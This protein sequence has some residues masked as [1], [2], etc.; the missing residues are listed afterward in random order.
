MKKMLVFLFSI[1]LASGIS[2]QQYSDWKNYSDLKNVNAFALADNKIWAATSGGVFSYNLSLQDYLILSKTDGLNGESITAVESDSY[3]KIWFGSADGKINV[4]DPSTK[5]IKTVLD[6]FNSDK[7]NKR[8]NELSVKGDTIFAATDFGISLINSENFFFYDTYFKFGTL[9]SNIKVNSIFFDGRIYSCTESGLAISKANAVNLSAPESWDVYQTANG[10]IS[11]NIFKVFSFNDTLIA[12]TDKGFSAFNGISWQP[13]LP[14]YNNQSISDVTIEGNSLVVLSQNIIRSYTNGN[15]TEIFSSPVPLKKLSSHDQFG[16]FAA[17]INGILN[18]TE[19]GHEFFVPNCPAANRFR[20]IIVDQEGVLFCASGKDNG[21]I[22]IM[23]LKNN[24]WSSYN[25]ASNPELQTNDYYSAYSAPDNTKYFGNWGRGFARLKDGVIT[26]F[27]AS[28]TDLVGI[29]EDPEFVVITS[30]KADSKNNIWA[31]NYW[32]AERQSL[33]MLQPN[34]TW[35]HFVVPAEQGRTLQLKFSLVIDAYNTKWYICQDQQKVGL[36]Y[37]NENGTYSETGDDKS[38]FLT[39]ANGLNN[40]SILSLAVDRRGDLWVGTVSGMNILTNTQAALTQSNSQFRISSSFLLRQQSINAIVVDP[41]NQKWV[42][43]NQGLL[44][45]NADGTRLIAA[46]DSRNSSLLSDQIVSLTMDENSG[47]IYA[48]TAEG[49]TSFKTISIKPAESFSE[50]FVYPSP[51]ILNAD[52]T[53]LTIDGLIRDCDIK[54][55]SISG[56]LI[57]K[58]VTPGGRVANW[59]G[60]DDFGNFVSSG[61]YLIVAYDKEGNSVSTTKVAVLRE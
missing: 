40:N 38:G 49:L 12:A 35:H 29:P 43:T 28:N 45:V 48:A 21:G 31:L 33:S 51:Y 24:L 47:T 3:G 11:N 6:I 56:K 22:G 4:Y 36:F 57:R 25:V 59:D 34:D 55:L 26:S 60:R 30:I 5:N 39:T 53:I 54:I 27:N 14:A 41:L 15:L 19:Q 18:V 8:I 13:F 58:F 42:G 9:T 7:S 17:S 61:V 1:L 52:N 32:S 23:Q 2:A 10:L 20:D 50:L 46:F 16:Y 44:L 37:F